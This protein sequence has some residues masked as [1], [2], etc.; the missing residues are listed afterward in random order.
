MPYSITL[1]SGN[2]ADGIPDHIKRD[3]ALIILRQQLPQEFPTPEASSLKKG[4]EQFGQ[5]VKT[6]LKGLPSLVRE[7]DLADEQKRSREA[8]LGSL[9]VQQN[10][11]PLV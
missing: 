8:I 1:P 5:A 10:L 3:D 7:E 4:F 6:G 2:I 11:S 9:E